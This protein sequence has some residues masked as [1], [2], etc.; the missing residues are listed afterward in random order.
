M[1]LEHKTAT[2]NLLIDGLGICSFNSE[3]RWW[4]V[5]F[6]HHPEH[7]LVLHVVHGY[8]PIT[9]TP[10][11][12]TV[13]IKSIGGQ[14]PDY[15]GEY[16]LGFFDGG[17]VLD[18]RRDEETLTAA[19]QENF[20]W[21]M[22]L[23]EGADVPQGQI[24]LKPPPYPVTMVYISDAV[25][26]AAALTPQNLFLVPLIANPNSIPATTLNQYLFGKT[27]DEIGADIRCATDGA[28]EISIEEEK[29]PPLPHNP[30]RPWQIRLMNMRPSMM[31]HN[32]MRAEGRARETRNGENLEQGDFQIYY[33]A[34]EVTGDKYSLWGYPS[35]FRSGRTD[36]NMPWVKGSNL[37]G[38]ISG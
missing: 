3:A 13:H 26:Y 32:L 10:E 14:T 25:F 37:S 34:L 2:A 36:C 11:T 20:R 16:P 30:E 24:T 38:L 7:E 1:T 6:M 21:A 35:Q 28:I 18:R 31:H 19:E 9:I 33:D 12:K 8:D 27:A 22:N 5:G 4:E 29:L 23:D 15:E 17:P